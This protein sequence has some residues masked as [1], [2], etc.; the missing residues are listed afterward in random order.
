MEEDSYIELRRVAT[1]FEAKSFVA[2]IADRGR[3]RTSIQLVEALAAL[4]ADLFHIASLDPKGYGYRPLHAKAFTGQPIGYRPFQRA[5]KL[6]EREGFIERLAGFQYYGNG[7][8]GRLRATATLLKAAD[9]AGIPLAALESHF[10]RRPRVRPATI[11]HPVRLTATSTRDFGYRRI[12]GVPM[13]IDPTHP[14]VFD[15]LRRV[16]EFNAYMAP[17]IIEPDEHIAFQRI[18]HEGDHPAF[19]WDRGGRLYS[20]GGGFQQL[21]PN[22]R[23]QITINGEPTV[24]IDIKACFPTILHGLRRAKFDPQTAYDSVPGL[25]RDV[26][27]L[28]VSMTLSKS[29][30]PTRWPPEQ[31]DKLRKKGI[32]CEDYPI[33]SINPVIVEH[34]PIFKDWNKNTINWGHLQFF[35]SSVMLDCVHKLAMEFN[36]PALPVHDSVIVPA[37]K[38]ALAKDILTACFK[39]RIGVEPVLET[40]G[41][42]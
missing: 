12:R 18:F 17:Q 25:P 2:M 34:L 37:S 4:V 5:L 26:V 32:D 33:K 29:T 10:P 20:L 15:S 36:V 35:E 9:I 13:P 28:W 38:E 30:L 41:A 40:K 27:K 21:P 31:K 24:E 7:R 23:Q 3:S 19:K 22:L 16:A 42:K 11:E 14:V 6:L 8:C 39:S 1:S